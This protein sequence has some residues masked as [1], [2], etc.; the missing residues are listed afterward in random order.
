MI[1]SRH[2]RGHTLS[3]MLAP[4][5]F[6]AV[7]TKG[8]LD[9]NTQSPTISAKENLMNKKVIAIV[10]VVVAV[11]G[12]SLIS[13]LPSAAQEPPP[14]IAVELLTPRST[15]TDEEVS[16]KLRWAQNQVDNIRHPSRTVVA[17]ITVQPGAHFPW[18]THPGPVFV[19]VAQGE[20]VYVPAADCTERPYP[21][22]TAFVDPGRGFV[23]TAFN[24]GTDVTVI[25]ATFFEVPET[26]PITITEGVV[27]PDD[28]AV[29]VGSHSAH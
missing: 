27:P 1:S 13:I 18:H 23:H 20:L 8:G 22:G 19:N 25:I 17:R 9:E 29:E 14:P 7:A 28:C 6:N 11:V 5:E 10:C 4:I 3:L 2:T 24:P 15:F 21:A 16:F 12:V 26:G